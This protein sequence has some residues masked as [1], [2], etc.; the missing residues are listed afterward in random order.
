MQCG[1]GGG[2]Q[3]ININRFTLS[4][5]NAEA[6]SCL[7]GRATDEKV[8]RRDTGPNPFRNGQPILQSAVRGDYHKFLSA[9][10]SQPI[11]GAKN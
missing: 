7:N 2:Q 3:P 6:D 1:I 9:T 10:A 4:S 8:I 11:V 5:H